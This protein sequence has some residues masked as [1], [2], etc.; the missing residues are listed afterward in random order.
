MQKIPF[1]FFLLLPLVGIT[2]SKFFID[3]ILEKKIVL[4]PTYHQSL[5]GNE[6]MFLKMN[7]AQAEFIDTTGF[8]KLKQADIFSVDLVFSDY[9]SAQDLKNLNKKRIQ[10]LLKLF[11]FLKEKKNIQWQIIRQTNGKDKE[12]SQNLLH[13]FVINYR[14][15]YTK[16]DKIKELSYIKTIVASLPKPVIPAIEK[17]NK[18]LNSWGIIHNGKLTQPRIIKDRIIKEVTDNKQRASSI[19]EYGDS[20]IYTSTSSAIERELLTDIE[21][22]LYGKK[23]SVYIILSSIERKEKWDEIYPTIKIKPTI[24]DSTV[25]TILKRNKFK[26]VL[27]VIDVTG[28]MSEYIAQLLS[29]LSVENNN[30]KYVVCFNDGN[31]IMNENKIIGR[32]GGIYGEP[33]ENIQQI[34]DLIQTAMNNGSGGDLAENDCEAVLKATTMF[35]GYDDVVLIA[36]NWA[37]VRDKELVSKISKPVHVIVCGG[38]VGVHP[39]YITIALKTNGSLHFINKDEVDLLSLKNGEKVLIRGRYYQLANDKV[40]EVR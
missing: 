23:D 7:Y 10:S 5:V 18:K 14:S 13:G 19:F 8:Y 29:W 25:I 12:S 11:P 30:I 16:Q 35:K 20:I 4:L 3:S 37:P 17:Q 32:T 38:E 26:N 15:A 39:D 22:D 36:D 24:Y 9:P 27:I 28:S 33:F 31:G 6:S 21:K 2:Q 1:I 34:G 40:V